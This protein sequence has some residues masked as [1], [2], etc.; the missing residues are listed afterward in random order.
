MSRVKLKL[1]FS[2]SALR[3]LESCPVRVNG[4]Q[5]QLHLEIPGG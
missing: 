3:G 1:P 4:P 2:G 5:L